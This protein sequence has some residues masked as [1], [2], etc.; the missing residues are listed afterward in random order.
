MHRAARKTSPCNRSGERARQIQRGA[1]LGRS[2]HTPRRREHN[3]APLPENPRPRA[4]AERVRSYQADVGDMRGINPL[5]PRGKKPRSGIAQ[6]HRHLR[7]QKL[8]RLSARLIHEP[9]GN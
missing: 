2:T 7:A 9:A 8:L 5:G 4:I 1:R 3:D 6:T